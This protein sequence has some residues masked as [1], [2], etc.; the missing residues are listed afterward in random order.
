MNV[1]NID[2]RNTPIPLKAHSLLS[3]TI[4]NTFKDESG[5][6]AP[7]MQHCGVEVR[8]HQQKVT[9]QHHRK[10]LKHIIEQ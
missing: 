9:N 8:V 7:S 4:S 1:T 10:G 3:A 2:R 6:Q 5:M